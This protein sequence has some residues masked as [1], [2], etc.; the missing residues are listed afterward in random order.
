MKSNLIQLYTIRKW[1]ELSLYVYILIQKMSPQIHAL[2]IVNV[3]KP[4][5]STTHNN[6]MCTQNIIFNHDLL[7][8]KYQYI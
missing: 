6:K 5:Q 7:L 4:L 2:R 8:S 3:L 1:Q